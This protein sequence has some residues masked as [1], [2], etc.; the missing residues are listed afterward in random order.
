MARQDVIIFVVDHRGSGKFGKQGLDYM[1]RN[2]GKWE[3]HDYIEAAKWLREKPFVDASRMGIQGGSYGGYM[4]ALALTLGADYFT[5]G[6][7]MYPVTD[8][9][10]YDNIYTERY[11][12]HP[13]DNPGGYNFGSV[14]EHAEKL[15]GKLLLVHGMVDDN[16]HL[17][18]TI[19]LASRL[20]EL[21]KK[22]EMMLYPGERHGWGG[23]KRIHSFELTT[24]F[25]ERA[26]G[27]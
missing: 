16:V 21:G 12:D 26:F 13:V 23:A 3:M 20:Q 7:S 5:H 9:R 6:V 8:W 25:W 10:L 15:K 24:G 17:Q 2:L 4:A 22:F 11:M 27:E 1:H 19:Q 18:N 14:L